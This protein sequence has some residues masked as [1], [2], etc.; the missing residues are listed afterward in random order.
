LKFPALHLQHPHDSQPYG[1]Y[2]NIVFR[3][4]YSV[5]IETPAL[6]LADYEV[7][8]PALFLK[9]YNPYQSK[10]FQFIFA[11]TPFDTR[12][13]AKFKKLTKKTVIDAE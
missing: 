8:L 11:F 2:A 9:V 5:S 6:V 12:Y 7:Y 10:P 1:V 4:K 3:H 13:I